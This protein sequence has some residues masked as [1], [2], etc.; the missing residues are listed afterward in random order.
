MPPRSCGAS[1]A[2]TYR[3]SFL[4]RCHEAASSATVEPEKSESPGAVEGGEATIVRRERIVVLRTHFDAV[5]CPRVSPDVL[6]AGAERTDCISS[7][8]SEANAVGLGSNAH[9][10]DRVCDGVTPMQAQT[11]HHAAQQDDERRPGQSAAE[12]DALDHPV[13]IS[14]TIRAVVTA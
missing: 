4:A 13:T 5:R 7:D 2:A 8:T 11:R 12:R 1:S 14:R 3:D 9:S 10:R 6:T